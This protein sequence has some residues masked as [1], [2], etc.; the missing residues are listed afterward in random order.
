MRLVIASGNKNKIKEIKQILSP[1]FSDIVSCAEAGFFKDIE[2]N[3]ETFFENALIKAE[4][5]TKALNCAAIADD[6]GLCVDA[7]NGKPGVLSARYSGK[8]GNDLQ[9]NLKLLNDMEKQDNRLCCFVCSVVLCYSDGYFING[10][11]STEGLLLKD[12]DGNNGFGYDSLFYSSELKKSFGIAS[13]E[14]KNSISHRYKALKDLVK[15]L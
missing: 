15:K 9:N 8:H 4:T 6:S 11:G 3:G 14:E 1:Y 2:E 7:L 10:E 13:D 12:F 5:V